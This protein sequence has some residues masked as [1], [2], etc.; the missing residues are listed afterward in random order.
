MAARRP[1]IAIVDDDPSVC[2]ALKR[3]L[4]SFDMDADI[5]LDGEALLSQL[6]DCPHYAPDCYVVDVLM[7]RIGG[8]ELQARLTAVRAQAPVVFISASD[9]GTTRRQVLE[10]GAHACLRKPF[11]DDVLVRTVHEAMAARDRPL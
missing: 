2:R 3:L 7:P 11:D 9:D 5:F 8:L 1:L 10:C 4:C 6:R